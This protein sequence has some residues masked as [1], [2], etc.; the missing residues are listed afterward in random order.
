MA[1]T[2]N[3]NE[4]ESNGETLKLTNE[5]RFQVTYLV[6]VNRSNQQNCVW[7]DVNPN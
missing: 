4:G 5:N 6:K 1:H 3:H 2:N 7:N